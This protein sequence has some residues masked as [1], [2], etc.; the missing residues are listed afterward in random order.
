M[1]L[2]WPA[3]VKFE[4]DEEEDQK[5]SLGL[6]CTIVRHGNRPIT[7]PGAPYAWNSGSAYPNGTSQYGSN[8]S[9][10]FP[11]YVEDEDN[12]S[13]YEQHVP[14]PMYTKLAQEL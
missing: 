5:R 1:I 6:V 3:S 11:G 4:S 8:A 13:K 12:S 9:C 7:R 14:F 10:Q 2:C